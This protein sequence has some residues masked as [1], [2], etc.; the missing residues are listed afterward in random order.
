MRI[1]I[2]QAFTER[3]DAVLQEGKEW[4]RNPSSRIAP[5][6]SGFSCYRKPGAG[7][8]SLA[9]AFADRNSTVMMKNT[10][11]SHS[12]ALFRTLSQTSCFLLRDFLWTPTNRSSHLKG[13]L[14]LL[15]LFFLILSKNKLSLSPY[16]F[17]PIPSTSYTCPFSSIH[18]SS[19]LYHSC[20]WLVS[21]FFQ[22]VRCQS[23]WE[24]SWTRHCR[25]VRWGTTAWLWMAFFK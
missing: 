22:H 10:S 8:E 21:V 6:P 7:G 1:L 9:K 17:S 20:L 12:M 5:E 14:L 25:C 13:F 4:K 16:A 19:G 18:L 11:P 2:L 24:G 15:P 3:W 23:S